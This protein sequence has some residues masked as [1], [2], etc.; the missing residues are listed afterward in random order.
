MATI[1]II[2]KL[3]KATD[4][5]P[6]N[7]AAALTLFHQH[8]KAKRI[9]QAHIE[10]QIGVAR[11]ELEHCKPEELIKLQGKVKGLRVALGCLEVGAPKK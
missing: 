5:T 10:D 7:V 11:S 4:D 9:L 2:D 6:E 1:D 8:A 3:A